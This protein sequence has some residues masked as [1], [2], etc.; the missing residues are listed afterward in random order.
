MAMSRR[1]N[2]QRIRG[3]NTRP[4]MIVRQ[5]V[6]DLGFPGYRIHRTDVLGVPDL[7]FVGRKLAIFVNGCFWHAHACPIGLRRPKSNLDYWLPKL[8]RT[9]AR[10]KKNIDALTEL[11]WR[12]L[13]V[14]ECELRDLKVARKKLEK[15]LRLER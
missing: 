15:F 9:Q 8:E 1:E 6:R 10:D 7:V 11:G 2:M 5:L 12:V 3:K 13:V 14:W 4:E